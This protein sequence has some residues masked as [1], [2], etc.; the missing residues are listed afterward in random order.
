MTD[1]EGD[2][3]EWDTGERSESVFFGGRCFIVSLV[4]WELTASKFVQD[5][6]MYPLFFFLRHVVVGPATTMV[7]SMSRVFFFFFFQNLVHFAAQLSVCW[8]EV[9]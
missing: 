1:P 4:A 3:S 2:G 9:D 7:A 8:V 6:S 5:N